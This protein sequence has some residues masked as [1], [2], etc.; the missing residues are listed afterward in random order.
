M[1]ITRLLVLGSLLALAACSSPTGPDEKFVS[2]P[3]AGG[4]NAVG[5]MNPCGPNFCPK[6]AGKN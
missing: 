5:V 4:G 2:R 1:Q 3:A 6:T